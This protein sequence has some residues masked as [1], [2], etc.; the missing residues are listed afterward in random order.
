MCSD[1]TRELTAHNV[2]NYCL[3]E[4]VSTVRVVCTISDF[5][6]HCSDI[7]NFV[8]DALS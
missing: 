5:P 4:K 8:V 6:V 1:S 2:F 7:G 3:S